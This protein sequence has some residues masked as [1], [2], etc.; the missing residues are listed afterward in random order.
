[1][2]C[3]DEEFLVIVFENKYPVTVPARLDADDDMALGRKELLRV[4]TVSLKQ[5]PAAVDH[6]GRNDLGLGVGLPD[7]L[8]RRR[9][10]L[11]VTPVGRNGNLRLEGVQQGL[12][13]LGYIS[14]SP[15]GVY[16][17][18][19]ESAVKAYQRDHGMEEIGVADS[20]LVR[21]IIEAGA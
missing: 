16:G 10:R 7:P 15:D 1:M 5:F 14:S 9:I 19:C 18:E 8:H 6:I 3:L 2:D 20:D 4:N 21:T 13:K 17:A 12:L 11:D